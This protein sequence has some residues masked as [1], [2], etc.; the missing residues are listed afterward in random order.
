MTAKTI[1]FATRNYYKI[2]NILL[3]ILK[4][5]SFLSVYVL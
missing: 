2:Y 5:L 3:D 1:A 4:D